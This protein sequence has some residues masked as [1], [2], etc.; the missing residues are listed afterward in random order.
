MDCNKLLQNITPCFCAFEK[1]FQILVLI[2]MKWRVNILFVVNRKNEEKKKI[3]NKRKDYANAQ[4]IHVHD[5]QLL[6]L[7][8]RYMWQNFVQGT[9]Q[10]GL[11][12]QMSLTVPRVIIA[13]FVFQMNNW[14]TL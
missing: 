14:R 8:Y 5:I 1:I 7:R 2:F 4:I 13:T 10:S 3:L 11:E 9:R 12:D 6:K